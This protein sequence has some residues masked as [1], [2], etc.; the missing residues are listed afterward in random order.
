MKL[1]LAG[2]SGLVGSHILAQAVAR[3]VEP[4]LVGRR[5]LST[6]HTEIL[7]TFEQVPEL[8]PADA[9]ICTLGTTIA[10]AGSRSA[11]YAVDHD[12]VLAFAAAARDAGVDHFLVVTAV[13]ASP[14]AGVYYSRVKGEVERD[15]TALGFR[16]LD[17]VQPGLLLGDRSEHRPVEQFMQIINPVAR[18]LLP[19]PL[20]RYAGIKAETVASALLSLGEDQDR[21]G[22]FRYENAALLS[23]GT[24]S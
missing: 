4:V 9:A 19:G 5:S 6:D 13:G 23:A 7:T 2:A 11:F 18:L 3:G 24:H 12:A 10:A 17:I 21:E 1:L 15:L 16:C 8:P 20:S 14:K 22:V